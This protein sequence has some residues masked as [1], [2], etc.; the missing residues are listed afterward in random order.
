M[1]GFRKEIMEF[2]RQCE[3]TLILRIS[4]RPPAKEVADAHRTSCQSSAD[5]AAIRPAAPAPI[6]TTFLLIII[7]YITHYFSVTVGVNSVTVPHKLKSAEC[8]GNFIFLFKHGCNNKS[9]DKT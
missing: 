8:V 4:R 7:F 9:I 5:A 6:T 1:E 3:A 2:L